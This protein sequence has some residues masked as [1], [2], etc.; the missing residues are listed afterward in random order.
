MG[1]ATGPSSD[2]S[3]T[4]LCYAHWRRRSASAPTATEPSSSSQRRNLPRGLKQSGSLAHCTS[5]EVTESAKSRTCAFRAP[6]APR[7]TPHDAAA[8][9]ERSR[10]QAPKPDAVPAAVR[11]VQPEHPEIVLDERS[12]K[13][14]AAV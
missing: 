3:T 4:P 2:I 1:A 11:L 10:E 5:D 12:L 14:W 6:L 8:D 13:R 7:V 9:R